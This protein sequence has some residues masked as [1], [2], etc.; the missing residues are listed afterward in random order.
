MYRLKSVKIISLK[1]VCFGTHV[2]GY[3]CYISVTNMDNYKTLNNK[4]SY[5]V[6][7]HKVY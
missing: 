2:C 3:I 5:K 1:Y 4:T 6:I 7:K